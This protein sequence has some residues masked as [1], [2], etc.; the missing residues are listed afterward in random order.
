[1]CGENCGGAHP[2][3][4]NRKRGVK[5]MSVSSLESESSADTLKVLESIFDRQ[6]LEVE[7]SDIVAEVRRTGYWAL[8]GALRPAF[9][10]AM[11]NEFEFDRYLVNSNSMGVVCA[12]SQRFVSHCLAASKRAYDVIT[13]RRV[14]EIC[15]AYFEGPFKLTNQRIYQTHTEGHMPWHTDN[16]CQSGSEL[17]GKHQL[18]GLL[19]LIYLSDVHDNAFQVLRNSQEWSKA[20]TGNYFS[21]QF[22]EEQHGKDVVSFHGI[23]GTLFVC[24]IHTIHRAAPFRK[25]GFERFTL[26]FQVD[27]VSAKFP[28][29]GEK[30]LVNTAFV[31]RRDPE[32]LDYLGFGKPALYPTFPCTTA[33]SMSVRDL[34]AMQR[35]LIPM[36]IRAVVRAWA[37]ALIP[38]GLLVNIKRL[39]WHLR[40]GTAKTAAPVSTDTK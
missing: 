35:S 21:D 28:E 19:F 33:A 24:D 31:D 30:L 25:R 39:K 20:H 13:S 2:G 22:I 40:Q 8:E 12:S 36:A 9:V 3:G 18:E 1:M 29:H 14:M 10:E 37:K 26:L 6:F 15:R 32:V 23:R 4:Q 5:E 7:A 16:N 11:R 34:W 27:A 17:T 38:G